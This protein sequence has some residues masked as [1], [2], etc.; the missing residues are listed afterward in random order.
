MLRP[1]KWQRTDRHFLAAT[2]AQRRAGE[3]SRIARERSVPARKVAV[4][5]LPL[6]GCHFSAHRHFSSPLL[7]RGPGRRSARGPGRRPPPRGPALHAV[8][9]RTPQ[10]LCT[11]RLLGSPRTAFA[12]LAPSR[13][14]VC[15][16]ISADPSSSG[17]RDCMASAKGCIN[18]SRRQPRR[19]A[20]PRAPRTRGAPRRRRRGAPKGEPWGAAGGSASPPPGRREPPLRRGVG[21]LVPQ[22]GDAARDEALGPA[23]G[24][25]ALHAQVPDHEVQHEERAHDHVEDDDVLFDPGH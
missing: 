11:S 17:P 12:Q 18:Q 14:R 8:W 10:N 23:S 16:Q 22:L 20:A 13:P 15:A 6:S 9:S 5:S 19:L 4:S 2:F 3:R 24:D 21:V 7:G 1:K 25:P